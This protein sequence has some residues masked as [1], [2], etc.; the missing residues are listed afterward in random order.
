LNRDKY[1]MYEKLMKHLE[2]GDVKSFRNFVR[3][4]PGMFNHGVPLVL[5]VFDHLFYE[6]SLEFSVLI[7]LL[8]LV[9][10]DR[11]VQPELC[12]YA[13]VLICPGILFFVQ[14]PLPLFCCCGRL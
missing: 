9:V 13:L 2:Q 8:G 1:G 10:V 6:L 14:F 4:D 3:M 7:V 5:V 11:M 12:Q